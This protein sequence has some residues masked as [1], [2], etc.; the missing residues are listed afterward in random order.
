MDLRTVKTLRSINNAFLQLRSKKPL[1]KITI[2]ELTEIAEISK[3]T[4]YLH[5]ADI[6]DLSDKLENDFI[7][8]LIYACPIDKEAFIS[9]DSKWLSNLYDSF[10]SQGQLL[11]IL[12]SYDRSYLFITKLNIFFKEYV[13]EMFPEYKDNVKMN[14]Y[15]DYTIH[16]VFNAYRNNIN[17]P[18]ENVKELLITYTSK[19]FNS[20]YDI[21]TTWYNGGYG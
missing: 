12:F 11:N 7:K 16:G 5:Y 10:V 20:I 2:R 19:F 8:E 4:F 9:S 6:Y 14:L 13:Y 1:S 17:L 21:L 15:L 3:P 18:Q